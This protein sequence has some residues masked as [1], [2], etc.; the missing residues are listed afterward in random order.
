MLSIKY[1]K[2]NVDKVQQAIDS[3]N[4]EFNLDDVLKL[5]DRRRSIIGE[6]EQLKSQRNTKNKLISD[7]RKEKRDSSGLINEMK[8]FSISVS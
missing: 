8:G 6:V 2:D 1:I 4:V 7:Y 3:K 5:D